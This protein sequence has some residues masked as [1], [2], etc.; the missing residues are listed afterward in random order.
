MVFNDISCILLKL[1]MLFIAKEEPI[2]TNKSNSIVCRLLYS[3]LYETRR[4]GRCSD[5]AQQHSS[6]N[7]LP[8]DEEIEN[9]RKHTYRPIN[10]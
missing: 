5:P 6:F 3:N 7:W 9:L 4:L 8:N 2:F 10:H 1:F